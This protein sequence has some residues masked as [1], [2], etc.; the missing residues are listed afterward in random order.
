MDLGIL[1]EDEDDS[2]SLDEEENL[3]TGSDISSFS[4]AVSEH[5]SNDWR[6]TLI[7]CWRHELTKRLIGIAIGVV[8]L[9]SI[10][11]IAVGSSKVGSATDP[12]L[13]PWMGVIIG[14]LLLVLCLVSG[15]LIFRSDLFGR[16]DRV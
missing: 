8:V 6:D 7:S 9:L 13:L 14:L 12:S 4:N 10:V 2:P 11:L 3:W 16:E 5:S 1:M 15:V